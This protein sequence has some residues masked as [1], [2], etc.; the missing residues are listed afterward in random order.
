MRLTDEFL[1]KVANTIQAPLLS[2]EAP[3]RTQAFYIIKHLPDSAIGVDK[4]VI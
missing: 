1:R 2:Q 3:G 4:D